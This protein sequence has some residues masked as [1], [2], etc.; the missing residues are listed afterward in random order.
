MDISAVVLSKLLTEKNLDVYSKLKLVFLDPAYASLYAVIGKHYE[1]YG[2]L[3][4]F[5]DLELTLREGQTLSRK[6]RKPLTT[7]QLK[8]SQ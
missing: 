4:T 7:S 3:P 2:A 8:E 6:N 5:D 1:K